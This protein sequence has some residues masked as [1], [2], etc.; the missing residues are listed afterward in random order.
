MFRAKPVMRKRVI[1][2]HGVYVPYWTNALS[3]RI[4]R[5]PRVTRT[6]L[7]DA[8]SVLFAM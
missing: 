7:Y 1:R 3:V 5:Q 6:E 2:I 8:W 4:P